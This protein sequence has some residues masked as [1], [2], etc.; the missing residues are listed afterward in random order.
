MF[1]RL[2]PL[3]DPVR[4]TFEGRA[5]DAQAGD[6]VAVAL[7]AAGEGVFR[8]TPQSGVPRALYCGMGTCFD[9]LVTI[10]GIPNRQSCMVKAT[11]GMV[12]TVQNGAAK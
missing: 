9:C 6:T 11:K 4:F 3:A 8:I 10:D 2:T 5:I 1:K 7:L 12:V